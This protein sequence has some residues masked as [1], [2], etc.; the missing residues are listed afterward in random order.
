MRNL[1][2][3]R[4]SMELSD[5]HDG[6]LDDD[7]KLPT[8]QATV[9]QPH[10]SVVVVPVLEPAVVSAPDAEDTAVDGC[11]QL[12]QQGYRVRRRWRYHL[13]DRVC[14]VDGACLATFFC[15]CFQLGQ[16]AEKLKI[17]GIGIPFLSYR[18]ITVSYLVL[19]ILAALLPYHT[20]YRSYLFGNFEMPGTFLFLCMVLIRGRV[21][22][23]Y[24]IKE[25]AGVAEDL[26][27]SWF[28][29]PCTLGQLVG[30][31]W[32]NPARIPGCNIGK[33]PVYLV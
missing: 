14:T 30:Q 8:A 1:E 29:F 4:S 25:G 28:C 26:C 16:I 27:L 23:L 7:D 12:F 20:E 24:E 13:G 33:G 21:K 32:R 9:Q 19:Y 11:R 17:G 22:K 6:G 10:F 31:V 2:K 3:Q 18:S 5:E 15:A